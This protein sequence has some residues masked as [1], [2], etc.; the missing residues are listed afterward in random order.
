[1]SSGFTTPGG[2]GRASSGRSLLLSGERA[3]SA[4]GRSNMWR[5]HGAS[6][7]RVT[8][9]SFGLGEGSSI[10]LSG[11]RNSP[12]PAESPSARIDRRAG[13]GAQ[14]ASRWNFEDSTFDLRLRTAAAGHEAEGAHVRTPLPRRGKDSTEAERIKDLVDSGWVMEMAEGDETASNTVEQRI[15]ESDIA[16]RRQIAQLRTRR[17]GARGGNP[18]ERAAQL[19][20]HD[21]ASR[22][23]NE[24]LRGD[25]DAADVD[26]SDD[27]EK[28]LPAQT[29]DKEAAA[30]YYDLDPDDPEAEVEEQEETTVG[31]LAELYATGTITDETRVWTEGFGDEWLPYAQARAR[32]RGAAPPAELDAGTLNRVQR[33]DGLISSMEQAAGHGATH[34]GAL[35]FKKGELGAEAVLSVREAASR[36][37]MRALDAAV[38]RGE[39]ATDAGSSG[40]S[41]MHW[42]AERGHAAVLE[43]LIGVHSASPG[44]KTACSGDTPLHLAAMNGHTEAVR[45]LLVRGAFARTTNDAGWT[46]LKAAQFNSH[47][48][49][50]RL[51]QRHLSE[52]A[53]AGAEGQAEAAVTDD[54]D[55]LYAAPVLKG[56]RWRRGG[57]VRTKKA[58]VFEMT[59]E[60]L[61]A[62]EKAAERRAKHEERLQL[63]VAECARRTHSPMHSRTHTCTCK[64][65]ASLRAV[66]NRGQ[67]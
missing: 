41:A 44:A 26:K 16:L 66:S 14:T 55:Q 28:S 11:G 39:L 57:T 60:Q 52:T 46:A 45:T 59:P 23:L 32:L 62:Q 35:N 38:L 67:A 31:E 30:Y 43:H 65:A 4:R 29:V 42:A 7:G 19:L 13:S 17:A 24:Q 2:G 36:G 64:A 37:D 51:L 21:A 8:D 20:R 1:M 18:A 9:R 34:H 10:F 48:S 40:W 53:S 61:R 27:A 56:K 25:A 6:T 63:L 12:P 54:D 5:A 49:I 50:V 3:G 33:V 58:R 22:L 15:A 47:L